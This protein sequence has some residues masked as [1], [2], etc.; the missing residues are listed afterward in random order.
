LHYSAI[1]V[2]PLPM[3]T[4]LFR[5]NALISAVA[6]LLAAT[7]HC[8][9]A[10]AASVMVDNWATRPGAAVRVLLMKANQPTDA[11][12]LLPGGHG[13]INL[14]SQGHI[15]W[16]E[17]DFVMRSRWHYFDSGIA[18]L[19]PDVATDH[20]PPVSLAGFR[21]S[22]Q[23][24]DDLLALLR[25]LRGMAPKVWI[26]A[27]DTGATSALNAVA[28]GKADSI[29]GLVLVSPWLEEPDPNSTLL[30]DGLNLAL[31]R[32]P[33]LVIAH[34]SDACSAPDV[35]RIKQTAAAAKT[36]NFQSITVTGGRTDVLLHDPFGYAEGS[37]N[38]QAPHRLASL[39]EVV[40]GQI[41]DW[42][43]HTGATK[44]ADSLN[45][46]SL[47]AADVANRDAPALTQ[48]TPLSALPE[49]SQADFRWEVLR[50]LNAQVVNAE[51]VVAGQP[52]LRLIATPDSKIHTL[53]VRLSGLAKNQTYRIAAWVK[54]VAGGNVGL[55][56]FDRPDINNPPDN[57]QA[58]FDLDSHQALETVGVVRRDIEQHSNAWQ[59][60]W[61][62]LPTTDGEFV[63]AVRPV[64]GKDYQFDGDG[65]LGLLL[66]GIEVQPVE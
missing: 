53:A 22:P 43:H 12:M 4:V 55:A 8:A 48:A 37:C 27:Y 54:P 7:L 62:D 50:G 42:I 26:V 17:D 1:A 28:R 52:V 64:K 58:I 51:A 20:K 18:A 36:A 39:D 15:G 47:A 10:C 9:T 49:P 19:I 46:P 11:V 45:A 25:H 23:Q 21:T 63:I 16:G 30:I 35:E 66:G 24:A 60:V 6:A 31:G 41:I 44:L 29:A 32:M 56:A 5:P 14:D 57:G 13:N 59:K 40:T 3:A 65:K 2:N 34:Q 38:T 61:I 33:V